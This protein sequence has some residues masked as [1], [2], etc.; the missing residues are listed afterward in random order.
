[1]RERER[2]RPYFLLCVNDG[3][4]NR[5]LEPLIALLLLCS[6]RDAA[7]L[8]RTTFGMMTFSIMRISKQRLE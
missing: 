3:R 7:T 5:C 4:L 6:D 8:S 2:E 1:M